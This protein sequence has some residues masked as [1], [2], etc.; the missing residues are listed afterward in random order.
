MNESI[1]ENID[2]IALFE[3]GRIKPLY[4]KWRNRK[5]KIK[6]V[7]LVHSSKKGSAVLY[8]FSVSDESNNYTLCFDSKDLSW[9]L[10]EIY[11]EG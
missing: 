1:N 9:E 2:V 10:S 3:Q 6:K 11:T 4:F 7:N 5:Y 8:H